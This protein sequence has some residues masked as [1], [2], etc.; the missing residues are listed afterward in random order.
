MTTQKQIRES[1]W[2]TFP[3]LEAYARGAGTKS[4]PQ[5]SQPVAIRAAFCDFVEMLASDGTISQE[6][7]Q[8]VTL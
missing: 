8:K 3:K 6:L 5:N 7:A 1:F 4:K 2:E